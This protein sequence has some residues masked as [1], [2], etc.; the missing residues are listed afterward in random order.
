ML[1]IVLA[2]VA[3]VMKYVY[4]VMSFQK[5][6][7]HLFELLWACLKFVIQIVIY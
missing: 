3:V 1:F 4:R 6:P 7:N 2:A 5:R